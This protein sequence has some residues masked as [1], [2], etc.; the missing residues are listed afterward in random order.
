VSEKRHSECEKYECRFDTYECQKDTVKKNTL[1]SVKTLF[2][3]DNLF[4][5]ASV[6]TTLNVQS[7]RKKT[8]QDNCLYV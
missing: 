3:L 5:K 8:Q 6:K 4:T 1:M 7:G 2:L